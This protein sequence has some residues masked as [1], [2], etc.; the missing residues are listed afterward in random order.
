MDLVTIT[1]KI[2]DGKLFNVCSTYIIVLEP[3]K[4]CSLFEMKGKIFSKNITCYTTL[5][6]ETS[7]YLTL[8]LPLTQYCLFTYN[9]FIH[10][11]IYL[12]E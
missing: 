1:E 7:E 8:I 10:Y 6:T 2:F 9:F 4:C 12:L 11:L 5:V 3:K